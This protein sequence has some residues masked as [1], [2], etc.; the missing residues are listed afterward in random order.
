MNWFQ[1]ITIGF[2]LCAY[3]L[4]EMP[5]LETQDVAVLEETSGET[6][7]MIEINSNNEL[8][9]NFASTKVFKAKKIKKI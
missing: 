8:K 1:M 7:N 6:N 3:P 9:F 5:K 4:L 2:L